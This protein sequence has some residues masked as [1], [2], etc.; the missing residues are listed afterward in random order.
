[1]ILTSTTRPLYHRYA[2]RCR[3]VNASKRFSLRAYR[4]VV[5]ARREFYAA[6]AD[7]AAVQRLTRKQK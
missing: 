2:R 5:N 1:M 6:L 4:A 7:E 3:R